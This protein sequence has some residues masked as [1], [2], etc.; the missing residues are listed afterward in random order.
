[1]DSNVYFTEVYPIVILG[2]PYYFGISNK[3]SSTITQMDAFSLEH[4][5]AA[6]KLVAASNLSVNGKEFL[7]VKGGGMEGCSLG[8]T[9]I[10]ANK[11]KVSPS[12]KWSCI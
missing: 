8:G 3:L 2:P 11:H 7:S 9:K 6:K 10:L 1:M 4:W 12:Y 5:Q